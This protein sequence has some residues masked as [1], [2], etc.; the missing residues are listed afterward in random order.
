MSTRSKHAQSSV[1]EYEFL[2]LRNAKLSPSK[3]G[4]DTPV[5]SYEILSQSS[6]YH[7]RKRGEL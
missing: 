1:S 3:L 5:L 2:G 7:E 4:V 6:R